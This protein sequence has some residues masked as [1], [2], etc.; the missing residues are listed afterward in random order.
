MTA[1][2][3]DVTLKQRLERKTQ[4]MKLQMKQRSEVDREISGVQA[5]TS[6]ARKSAM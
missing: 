2:K 3:A 6:A 4:Q 5:V 1:Y